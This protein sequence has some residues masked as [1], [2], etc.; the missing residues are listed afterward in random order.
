MKRKATHITSVFQSF[1]L[2]TLIQPFNI[3]SLDG[4]II[5]SHNAIGIFR[6]PRADG[7]ESIFLT[8]SWESPDGIGIYL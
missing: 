2:D 1:G 6:A 7:T 4:K 5:T 3:T 8:A